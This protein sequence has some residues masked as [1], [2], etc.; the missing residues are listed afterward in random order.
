MWEL[1]GLLTAEWLPLVACL[2]WW[3]GHSHAPWRASS[4][5]SAWPHLIWRIWFPQVDHFKKRFCFSIGE[6]TYVV[7]KKSVKNKKTCWSRFTGFNICLGFLLKN[8]HSKEMLF[9]WLLY[10]WHVTKNA[11]YMLASGWKSSPS[12]REK[13]KVLKKILHLYFPPP[14]WNVLSRS[15]YIKNKKNE[16]PTNSRVGGVFQCSLAKDSQCL[17]IAFRM[18][19]LI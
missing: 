11:V 9:T 5:H 3:L 1:S 2:S 18:I 13:K 12:Q 7:S 19:D 4:I 16:N 8:L 15:S 14:E 10:V 6:M 17:L